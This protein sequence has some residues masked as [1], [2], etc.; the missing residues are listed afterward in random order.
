MLVL[1]RLVSEWSGRGCG[2]TIDVVG[3]SALSSELQWVL[4][5]P[6]AESDAAAQE[7]LVESLRRDLQQHGMQFVDDEHF[8]PEAKLANGTAIEPQCPYRP[9]SCPGDH[10]VATGHGLVGELALGVE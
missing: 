6:L 7:Q 1:N 9:E 5:F 2:L 10:L 4:A 8:D 3:N